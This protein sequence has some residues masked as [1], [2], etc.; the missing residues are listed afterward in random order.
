MDYVDCGNALNEMAYERSDAIEH[1][2]TLAKKFVEHFEKIYD[3]SN[4]EPKNHWANE[5]Q[6]WLDDVRGIVLKGKNKRIS[7]SQ[8][9]DW[10]FTRGSSVELMFEDEGKQDKYDEFLSVIGK[11]YDVK[12]ALREIGLMKDDIHENSKEKSMKNERKLIKSFKNEKKVEESNK[13]LKE[14]D[15]LK[16]FD[17]VFSDGPNSNGSERVIVKAHDTDEASKKAYNMP[18]AKRYDNVIVSERAK[19]NVA[20]IVAFNY[21][22]VINGK[23]DSR[24]GEGRI[25]FNADNENEAKR[26]YNKKYRGKYFDDVNPGKGNIL[27][28]IPTKNQG[29]KYGKVF[30]VYQLGS[31]P[32]ANA[33]D[34][35]SILESKD[36]QCESKEGD[37][38]LNMKENKR[39]FLKE[40]EKEE[41]GLIFFEREK[42]RDELEEASKKLPYGVLAWQLNEIISAMNDEGAYYES[43]WLYIWPDG[44]TRQDAIDS[45]STKEDYEE[46]EDLF[47][48][49][50]K[51]YHRSGLYKVSDKVLERAHQW[52]KKLGLSQITDVNDKNQKQSG[53]DDELEMKIGE[54]LKNAGID[55]DSYEIDEEY[56]YK[57]LYFYDN[58]TAK[59]AL[60]ALKDSNEFIEVKGYVEQFP[61]DGYGSI[62]V[63][64]TIPEE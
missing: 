59:K 11:D 44:A 43:G 26:A 41:K 1:C 35:K 25:V 37:K 34:A 16:E 48:R 54:V 7:F 63:L 8:L 6:S 38:G 52:D 42:E 22:Y 24:V 21:N 20:Y 40:N 27:D 5:M 4:D 46:L 49:V 45:F 10:F 23:V 53:F 31:K 57:D 17:V 19:G 33:E 12:R 30:D 3:E 64:V 60:K 61:R 39:L 55:E 14:D 51:R 56:N 2:S 29:G 62:E 47:K 28:D 15:E 18:Q 58:A 50:Y 32:S 13:S 9:V 36:V